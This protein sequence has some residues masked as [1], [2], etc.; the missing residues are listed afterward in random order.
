MSREPLQLPRNPS[1]V[2]IKTG[3]TSELSSGIGLE[4]QSVTSK[5]KKATA[6]MSQNILTSTSLQNESQSSY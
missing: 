6:L 4:T 2:S 1:S 3:W 5:E